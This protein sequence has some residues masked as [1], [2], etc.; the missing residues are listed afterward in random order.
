MGLT[1]IPTYKYLPIKDVYIA[2]HRLIRNLKLRDYFLHDDEDD[3][4]CNY[5]YTIK[6]FQEKSSWTPADH[7]LRQSTLDSIQQVLNTTKSIIQH[8]RTTLDGQQLILRDFADNLSID[9]RT[10]LKELKN[11]ADIII[12]PADKGSATVVMDRSAYIT[13]ALR[14]LNNTT[15]YRKLDR[16]IYTDNVKRIKDVLDELSAQRTITPKQRYFL[17]AKETDRQRISTCCPRSISRA[18]SGHRW[19]ECQT[20]DLSFQTAE[21]SHIE[22]RNT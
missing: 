6:T 3:D 7:K 21:A 9:E 15:Y 17:G 10:A 11:N 18:T 16:P 14:Q 4:E 20:E 8:R 13:E 22:Y 2:Q 19:T 12:K 5:D 1:F